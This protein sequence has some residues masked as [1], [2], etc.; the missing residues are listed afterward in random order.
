MRLDHSTGSRPND[1]RGFVHRRFIAGVK[2]FVSGGPLAALAGF[3]SGGGNGFAARQAAATARALAQ[4]QARAA[5]PQ[6]RA[7]TGPVAPGVFPGGLQPPFPGLP[8]T[9]GALPPPGCLP[10]FIKIGPVCL[11]DPRG[12]Q[13]GNGTDM[14]RTGPCEDPQL[15]RDADGR[16]R[17]PGSPS[18][19]P[20]E[21]RKGRFGAGVE[22]TFVGTTVRKCPAGMVLGK[23]DQFSAPLCYEKGAISNKERLWPVGTRPLLTGGEMAAIRKASTAKARV[24][25]TAK[26]LGIVKPAPRRTTQKALPRGATVKVLE[27]GPGSVQL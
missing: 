27:S 12:F 20:G 1:E 3:A 26:R 22:P 8:L 18:G 15:E 24:L 17:F 16:C 10:G 25:R 4:Q 13:N 7:P 9:T 21:A 19:P 6:F 23:G 14:V 11:P 2:G 5:V